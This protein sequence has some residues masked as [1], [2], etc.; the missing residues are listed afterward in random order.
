MSTTTTVPQQKP[1]LV[2]R[3]RAGPTKLLRFAPSVVCD[4]QRTVIRDQRLLQLVLAVLIDEFLVVC[5]DALGDGLADRVDLRGVTAPG[6]AHADIDCCEFV[7]AD[8]EEWLV[9]LE[10]ENLGLDEV[11]G[12]TVDFDKTA[13]GLE[14]RVSMV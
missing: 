2:P 1:T 5:H 7:E 6:D 9:D 11:E 13:A 4:E 12:G 8:N 3:P 14:E 10:A